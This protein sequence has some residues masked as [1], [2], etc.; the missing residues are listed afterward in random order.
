MIDTNTFLRGFASRNSA[1]T[2]L[3]RSAENRVFVTLLS[4][5]VLDEYHA[6][7]LHDFVRTKFPEITPQWVEKVIARLLFAG[8]Y[9]RFPNVRFEYPRDP[10]DQ[11]FVELAIK[12]KATH[13]LS[14]DQDLLSLP[15]SNSD[16][17]KRYRQRL[18]ATQIV[19]AGTFCQLYA[20]ELG[21][22]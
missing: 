20:D 21:I 7:L 3:L 22:C 16:A 8:E 17:G 9:V 13:I 19:D 18:P 5:P 15:G 2:R 6:V 14:S 10:A 11:K 4:K 1:A 12:L